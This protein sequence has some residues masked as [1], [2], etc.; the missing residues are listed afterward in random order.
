MS[1][2]QNC[3]KKPDSVLYLE[4]SDC[5]QFA[6]WSHSLGVANV[7]E[8]EVRINDLAHAFSRITIIKT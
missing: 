7:P 4:C 8:A 5:L 1:I 3:A 6:H 2:S